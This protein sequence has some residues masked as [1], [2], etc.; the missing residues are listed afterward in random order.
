MPIE[1]VSF[2]PIEVVSFV[3]AEVVSFVPAEVMSR[4][5]MV[6]HVS[7]VT[8]HTSTAVTAHASTAVT[9]HA[10]TAMTALACCLAGRAD[11][12]HDSQCYERHDS[13][14]FRIR[15]FPHVMPLLLPHFRMATV[16]GRFTQAGRWRS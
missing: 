14:L 16:A 12:Q 11:G 2:V 8:A 3:P 6:L 1:V 13:D 4:E 5:A 9:A 10:S 15:H 7:A